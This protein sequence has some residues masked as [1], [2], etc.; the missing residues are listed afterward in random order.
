MNT[1]APQRRN[2]NKE[3]FWTR[4]SGDVRTYTDAIIE[5]PVVDRSQQG[6]EVDHETE[7]TAHRGHDAQNGAHVEES[8]L[9]RSARFIILSRR[10]RS[11]GLLVRQQ[12][13]LQVPFVGRTRLG[14][15]WLL[16]ACRPRARHFLLVLH[17]SARTSTTWNSIPQPNRQHE[18]KVDGR[19]MNQH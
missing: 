13:R 18:E 17:H 14:G 15:S 12:R 1:S 9:L 16:L 2:P 7:Q 4:E 8:I 6:D 3:A 5:A 11:I 10:L 19:V